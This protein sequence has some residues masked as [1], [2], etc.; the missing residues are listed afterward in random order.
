MGRVRLND[1]NTIFDAA[2]RLAEDYSRKRIELTGVRSY[3]DD[4][5]KELDQLITRFRSGVRAYYG[6]DSVQY[7]QSG[8]TRASARKSP[9]R[10]AKTD[11]RSR[12]TPA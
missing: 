11:R 10:K 4:K 6:P 1:F 2:E 8:A 9:R 5:V 3:R 7:G 12:T